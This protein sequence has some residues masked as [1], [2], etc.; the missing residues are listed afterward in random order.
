M[1]GGAARNS[2]SG[3]V[4]SRVEREGV[5]DVVVAT[6][7]PLRVHLTPQS[8]PELGL[9]PGAR[10]VVLIKATAFRP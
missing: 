2:R 1:G 4:P 6:P 8:A 9:A 7:V 3:I 10:V 5:V